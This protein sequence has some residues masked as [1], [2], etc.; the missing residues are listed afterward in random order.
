MRKSAASA[1]QDIKSDCRWCPIRSPTAAKHVRIAVRQRRESREEPTLLDDQVDELLPPWD[2][3]PVYEP[4]KRDELD[5]EL[6]EP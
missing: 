2:V 6:L 4:V 5:D 3:L 1:R